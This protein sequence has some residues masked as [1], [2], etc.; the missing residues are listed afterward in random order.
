M[1]PGLV[2]PF[3]SV[4]HSNHPKPDS[5]GSGSRRMTSRV[6]F[7]GRE[8]R[9]RH[10]GI[11][12]LTSSCQAL[13]K[14]PTLCR[15]SR[16]QTA[17]MPAAELE[18]ITGFTLAARSLCQCDARTRLVS[19]CHFTSE[20]VAL[21][22][23]RNGANIHAS[24]RNN[25]PLSSSSREAAGFDQNRDHAYRHLQLRRCRSHIERSDRRDS[26]ARNEDAFEQR[27]IPV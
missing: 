20:N 4:S 9:G 6:E 12:A 5:Q 3:A 18:A 23:P 7:V 21:P 24:L 14:T 27:L 17:E 19:S 26:S 8:R 16:R 1:E 10:R 13:P 11:F 22:K 2:Y 25:V 15:S